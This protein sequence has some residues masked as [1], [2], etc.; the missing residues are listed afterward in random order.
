LLYSHHQ[1]TLLSHLASYLGHCRYSYRSNRAYP[2]LPEPDA[3][4]TARAPQYRRI[5]LMA[6]ALEARYLPVID[7]DYV[8][9]VNAEFDEYEAYRAS[10]APVA[11][12]QF[13]GVST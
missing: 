7:G 12:S 5:V 11:M 9:L 8:H 2:R 13:F 1:L 3:F 4:L 10:F 6:T